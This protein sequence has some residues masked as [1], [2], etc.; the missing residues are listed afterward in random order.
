[1]TTQQPCAAISPKRRA[2]LDGAVA[3]FLEHG[4]AD[5]SM[6]AVATLAGVSKATI[7]AHFSSK[8][9]LFAAVICRRCEEDL[10]APAQWPVIGTDV[11]ATLRHAATL[12]LNFM[13]APDTLAIHRVVVAEAIRQPDLASAFWE[14]GPGRG[15]S[16]LVDLFVDL[17]RA[18]QL[19]VPDPTILAVTFLNML[20]SEFFFCRLLG[21]PLG[22][23][24]IS[25]DQTIDTAVEMI[26]K[27]HAPD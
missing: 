9:D 7:Y 16:R 18:K 20:K 11:R 25:F 12:L 6:D 2:I 4:Y 21:L 17:D 26:V 14:A 15:I 27:A 8:A 24:R 3:C 22:T 23:E 13:I 5:A 19:K 10:T 1:M